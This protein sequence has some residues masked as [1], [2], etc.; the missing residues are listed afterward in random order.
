MSFERIRESV[1]QCNWRLVANTSLVAV[2][3][4]SGVVAVFILLKWNANEIASLGAG[5]SDSMAL[6]GESDGPEPPNSSELI[7]GETESELRNWLEILIEGGNDENLLA[8]IKSQIDGRTGSFG[9]Q[10]IELDGEYRMAGIN[11]QVQFTAAST[12]KLFVAYSVLL[13]I[14]SGSWGWEDVVLGGRTVAVCFEAMIV[15]SSNECAEAMYKKYGTRRINEDIRAVG[16]SSQSGWIDGYP[17]VTAFDL[18]KFLGKLEMGELPISAESRERLID[19]MKRDKYR[20]GIPSGLEG[21]EVANKTEELY[22]LVH[23]AAIVYSPKGTYVLVVL[24]DRSN[25]AMIADVARA[26]EAV[27]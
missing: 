11:Q 17:K 13:A 18:A 25:R 26:T 9:V 6:E 5:I 21:M 15:A 23:D 3:L 8:A 14:D 4:A 10:L 19:A 24:T 16:L 7:G 27:R 12:Y 1:R 20:W 2:I 22:A